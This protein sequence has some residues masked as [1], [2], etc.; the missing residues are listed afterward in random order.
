ML[1]VLLGCVAVDLP[2]VEFHD[3]VGFL[4]AQMEKRGCDEGR[5]CAVWDTGRFAEG[6]QL[7][8]VG[9]PCPDGCITSEEER[10]VF[11]ARFDGVS[12]MVTRDNPLLET[13]D[14]LGC[15][16]RD[17]CDAWLDGG[18]LVVV[19]RERHQQTRLVATAG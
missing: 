4:V 9:R 7:V 14:A 17:A 16:R 13:L 12:G 10:R 2:I 18:T 3:D 6:P 5:P 11:G 19:E 1:F 8:A 15:T